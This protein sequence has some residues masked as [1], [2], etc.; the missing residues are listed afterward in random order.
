MNT[1]GNYDFIHHYLPSG[2]ARLAGWTVNIPTILGAP[3]A[4]ATRCAMGKP[5]NSIPL[6]N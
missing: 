2:A 1:G 3:S 6:W 5:A 4:G